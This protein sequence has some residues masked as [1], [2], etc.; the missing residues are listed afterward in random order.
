M[1]HWYD[2]E[3]NP[4]HYEGKNGGDTT[5]REA[6]K[7]DLYPSVTTVGSITHKDALVK[8][9]QKEACIATV[10]FLKKGFDEALQAGFEIEDIEWGEVDDRWCYARIAEARAKVTAKADLGTEI[11]DILEKYMQ[12][13]FTVDPKYRK[14]CYAIEEC[15]KEHTG[16]SLY[17]FIPEKTFC[18]S[19]VG[20]GGTC[21]LHSKPAL[22]QWIIDYKTK[23]EV[24]EKTRGYEGQ[25]EQLAAYS[26]GL[27]RE[28]ARMAN[29]FIP[30]EIP[31]DGEVYVKF[32]EHKDANAWNRFYHQCLL[33]QVTKKYGP[34]YEA[35]ISE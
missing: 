34:L 32:Y 1:G 33:W 4:R 27:R 11:H 31:E 24:T 12:D 10:E 16:L 14:L 18:N 19:E 29:I 35:L 30:R 22:P 21:D 2:K 3:A 25:A 13:P 6:R 7:L 5:L 28:N 20:Y 9:L 23:D 26:R 17:D 15:I 8:W